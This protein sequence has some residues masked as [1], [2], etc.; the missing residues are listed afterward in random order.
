MTNTTPKP[1]IVVEL[2]PEHMRALD[3]A[4]RNEGLNRAS[5][6]RATIVRHLMAI[7]AAAV[8]GEAAR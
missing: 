6:A 5:F 8:T 2:D 7:E 3:R 1:R 4:R